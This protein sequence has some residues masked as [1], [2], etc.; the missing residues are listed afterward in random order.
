MRERKREG[1][2]ENQRETQT[3]NKVYI[4]FQV[5]SDPFPPIRPGLLTA[6]SAVN[7]GMD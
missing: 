3:G 7:S 1:E 2:R 5:H 4:F 6:H